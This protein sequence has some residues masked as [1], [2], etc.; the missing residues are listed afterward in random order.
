LGCLGH[1]PGPD[2]PAA[3]RGTAQYLDAASICRNAAPA[4]ARSTCQGT[5]PLPG[6]GAPARAPSP[7]QGT[8]PLPGHRLCQDDAPRYSQ[9]L[10]YRTWRHDKGGECGRQL[11]AWFHGR[12]TAQQGPSQPGAS[13]EAGPVAPSALTDRCGRCQPMQPL[14]AH[15]AAAASQ[16][17]A[18]RRTAAKQ[19]GMAQTPASTVAGPGPRTC[20]ASGADQKNSGVSRTELS[21]LTAERCRKT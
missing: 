10:S 8:E 1:E 11:C 16:G 21:R 17:L 9:A 7:C 20:M 15:A 2:D 12:C 14:P 4:T 3:V 6:H 5:E 18:E 13:N 19:Q